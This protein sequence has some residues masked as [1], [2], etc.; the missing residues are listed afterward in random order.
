MHGRQPHKAPSRLGPRSRHVALASALVAVLG[1][2]SCLGMGGV[3]ADPEPRTKQA[4]PH[5]D[6]AADREAIATA[7]QLGDAIASVAERVSPS[8]VSIR[9][10]ARR[11]AQPMGGLP[12]PFFGRPHDGGDQIQRGNGSGVIIRADGH[13][14]TNNHVVEHATRITVVLRDGRHLTGE[15]VG[16]DPATDLAVLKVDAT[17]LPSAPFADSDRIRPGQ[18]SVAIGSPFGLD[19]TV[20]AG[21]VSAVGRAGFGA[22]EIEDFIQTDAAINPGNSGG[23]LVD[24]DGRVLGI[25]T[26]IVGRGSGIGFAVPSTLARQVAN[27]IIDEGQVRRAWIGVSFQPLTPELA[28]HFGLTEGAPHGALVS[29]LVPDGPAAKAGVRPGDVILKVDGDTIQDSH[30]LLRS[31]LRKPVGAKVNLEVM[32]EGRARTL[33]LKTGERPGQSQEVQ[34]RGRPGGSAD[35]ASGLGL[36]LQPLTPDLAQRLDAADQKHGVVVAGV[37]PGTPADRA[38]LRQGDIIVNAD[39]KELHDVSQLQKALTDGKAVLRVRRGDG[40]FFTVL[41]KDG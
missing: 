2:G 19:Y 9:V 16:A 1:T 29:G 28:Q 13:I 6:V 10:E 35:P 14:L 41:Q 33:A 25:N 11:P 30:D 18:W 32:R 3:N 12:F 37:R 5:H 26:M 7:R 27:Q 39:R 34:S 21:V 40:S 20:T 15:L 17:N 36:R 22:A 23:P 38:G 8:V 4:T 24:L 31:V